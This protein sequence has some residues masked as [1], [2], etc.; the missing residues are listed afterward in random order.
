MRRGVRLGVDVG[1]TRVGLAACDPDGTLAYPVATLA[2][3][4]GPAAARTPPREGFPQGPG[5]PAGPGFPGGPGAVPDDIAQVARIATELSAIEII[6]GLPRSLDG[7]ERRAAAT[8]REYAGQVAEVCAP[9]P[10]RLVDE[11]LSTVDAH[12]ALHES[13]LAGRRH[14]RVVDQAAAVIILQNALEAER[15][16]GTAPGEP[17]STGRRKARRR[18]GSTR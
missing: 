14:R 16:S 11:R 6:V 2:R 4:H 7:S 8:A 5:F 15:A 18:K 9:V 12:R 10:V 13:G 1:S 17:V 3:E